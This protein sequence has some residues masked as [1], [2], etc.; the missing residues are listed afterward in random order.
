MAVSREISEAEASTARRE[1]TSKYPFNGRW[2]NGQVW[3]AH[4]LVDFYCQPLS[5]AGAAYRWAREVGKN[6]SV[7]T[8]G[9][10]GLLM[11]FYPVDSTWK[12]NLKVVEIQLRTVRKARTGRSNDR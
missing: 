8:I 2:D 10:T 5:L 11:Q 9:E 1:P 7:M 4:R 3:Y 12:P 6:V